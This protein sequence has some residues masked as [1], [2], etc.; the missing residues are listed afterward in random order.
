MT[1]ENWTRVAGIGDV[2]DGEAI[3][4]EVMGLDLAL[5]HVDGA[6]FCTS[7]VCTHAYALL[8][9]GWLD[10]H[11]IECPLHNGQFDVRT[12]KGMGAPITED[13]QAFAVRIEG[14]DVLVALPA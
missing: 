6:W 1:D 12:G 8:T 13:L 11:L 10:G 9:D 3:P 4:L 7:N 2:P 14:D 5:Y